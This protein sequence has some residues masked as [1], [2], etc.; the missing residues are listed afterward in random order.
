MSADIPVG[1]DIA[2]VAQLLGDST[3]A[4]MVQR[5]LRD[6]PMSATS[7][8]AVAGVS[9]PTAS[10][11]LTRLVAE[12][13]LK[14]ERIGRHTYYH[15][16]EHVATIVDALMSLANS[17]LRSPDAE[18]APSRDD[19]TSD[20]VTCY[21]H[22]GGRLGAAL[23]DSLA[24]RDLIR[25]TQR[26]WDV[27]PNWWD[28]VCP[29]GITCGRTRATSRSRRPLARSCVDWSE[30]SPHLAGSLGAAMCRQLFRFGWLVR[31]DSTHGRQVR[32]TAPGRIGL[33][34][35]FGLVTTPDQPA[36]VRRR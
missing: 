22:L 15:A 31:A 21:D 29:L 6:G 19:E 5:V 8:A 27:D 7:L 36:G 28:Q 9:R 30:H 4:L 24:H 13:L 34:Q 32:L 33:Y 16:G 25:R 3:R 1:P 11:H 2:V 10:A 18:R 20:G 26:G 17:P 23:A 35:V 12:G 14:V